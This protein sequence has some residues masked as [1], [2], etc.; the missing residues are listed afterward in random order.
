M[1]TS[2]GASNEGFGMEVKVM[3][4]DERGCCLTSDCK[5]IHSEIVWCKGK[6][7]WDAQ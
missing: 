1:L 3:R 6:Q 5:L 4:M 7:W 2:S